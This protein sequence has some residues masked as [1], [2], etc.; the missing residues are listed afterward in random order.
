MPGPATDGGRPDPIVHPAMAEDV[1]QAGQRTVAP[2]DH[3]APDRQPVDLLFES[4]VVSTHKA[5]SG[6]VSLT[7]LACKAKAFRLDLPVFRSGPWRAVASASDLLGEP[8]LGVLQRVTG[9]TRPPEVRQGS[10]SV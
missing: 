6:G 4:V 7:P 2:I 3:L 1:H 8:G 9:F 5:L 10:S